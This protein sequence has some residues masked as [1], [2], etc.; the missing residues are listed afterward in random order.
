M[1]GEDRYNMSLPV[2]GLF[3]F[4]KNA[5]TKEVKEKKTNAVKAKLYVARMRNGYTNACSKTGT[6]LNEKM[7]TDIKMVM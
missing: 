6:T 7:D 4:H 3:S 2:V 1:E 5:A